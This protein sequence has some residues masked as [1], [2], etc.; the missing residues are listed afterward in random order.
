M[1]IPG[2]QQ[3]ALSVSK[4]APVQP[5]QPPQAFPVVM[6]E[7]VESDEVVNAD[8]SHV[9]AELVEAQPVVHGASEIGIQKPYPK[10][11]ILSSKRIRLWVR[12]AVAGLLLV[13]LS[14]L[15][16]RLSLERHEYMQGAGYWD[17]NYHPHVLKTLFCG[18]FWTAMGFA[19]IYLTRHAWD[20]MKWQPWTWKALWLFGERAQKFA[21]Y[22][23]GVLFIVMF[24]LM[25]MIAYVGLF[26]PSELV[27]NYDEED[28]RKIN[29]DRM[30]VGLPHT[31]E[32]EQGPSPTPPVSRPDPV[33]QS[34]DQGTTSLLVPLPNPR[35]RSSDDG[36]SAPVLSPHHRL[37]LDILA[38]RKGPPIV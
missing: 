12:G 27:L 9:V 6:A 19:I 2:N 15:C 18:I 11:P 38:G 22:F 17:D 13:T 20:L 21:S 31:V 37:T 10:G 4:D 32:R 25:T 26:V 5:I 14:L 29:P 30:R 34:D 23:G 35:N 3:Q 33:N 7:I 1:L 24:G 8:P 28:M 36:R 16:W